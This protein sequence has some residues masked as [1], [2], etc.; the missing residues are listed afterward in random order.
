AEG[1][2]VAAAFAVDAHTELHLVVVEGELG[3]GITGMGAGREREA[4]GA[5]AGGGAAADGGDLGEVRAGLGGGAGGLLDGDGRG[6]AAAAGAAAG[7]GAGGG[8]VVH[9]TD[10]GVHRVVAADLLG[11]AEVQRVTGVFL[12]DLDHA[13]PRVGRLRGLE[14]LQCGGTGEHGAGGRDVEHADAHESGVQRLVP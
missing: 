3:L 9:K 10:P 1:D 4:H 7:G 13:A 5:G 2:P 12:D 6:G 11:D 14:D 8:V